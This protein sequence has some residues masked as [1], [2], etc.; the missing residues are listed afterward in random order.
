MV[1]GI[2]IGSTTTKAVALSLNASIL[3]LTTKAYDPITSATGALGKMLID[4]GLSIEDIDEIALTGAGAHKIGGSL[5]G[6]PT[7][8]VDEIT[9]I[10]WG[11][12]RLSGLEDV[13]IANLGTGTTLVEAKAGCITHI[14]GTGVGGGTI[15]GLAKGMLRISDIDAIFAMAETGRIRQV[16]L[17][18]ADIMDSDISF[19]KKETTAANFGKMLEGATREDIALGIVNMVYQ[20]I[21]MLSVFGAKSRGLRTIVVTGNASSATVGKRILDE[22]ADMYGMSFVYPHDAEYATSLG[23]ALSSDRL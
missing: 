19:L 22:V 5:F 7:H 9:A 2:D 20:V 6:V 17:L 21:G 23:A 15:V 18:V 14:G 8:I 4:N 3:K 10:G 11:G 12:M 16:D 13:V 1:V